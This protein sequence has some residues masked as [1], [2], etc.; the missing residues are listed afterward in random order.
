MN[1]QNIIVPQKYRR[2]MAQRS[3][4]RVVR[5]FTDASICGST[6]A[7]AWA[8][9]VQHGTDVTLLGDMFFES[10]YCST[11]AE[12]SA[13]SMALFLSLAH[14]L[15]LSGDRVLIYSDS[16]AAKFLMNEASSETRLKKITRTLR[17]IG[18]EYPF[19][20]GIRDTV[21]SLCNRLDIYA[22]IIKV[23][24]HASPGSATFFEKMNRCADIYA[25]A[26]MREW[27]TTHA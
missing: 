17:R 3:G 16:Q 23:Q 9:V 14:G 6:G 5:I 25:R 7:A 20:T 10:I 19:M 27:R 15:V 26:R 8:T 21:M 13:I 22:T 24:A 12:C 2:R 4:R 1:K 18:R 11:T